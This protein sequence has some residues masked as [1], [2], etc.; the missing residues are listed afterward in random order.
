VPLAVGLAA[1]ARPLSQLLGGEGDPLDAAVTYLRIS[2]LGVPFVL[3]SLVGAGVF[4]GVADL[5]TPLAIVFTASAANLLVEII[6]VYGLDLGIAGSA[7]STVL[8][9][10]LAAVAYLALMRP[11]LRAAPSARPDRA[12]LSALLRAG[13]H[14][15]LRV[16][17]L[18]AAFAIATA[19]AARVD[20]A[21][22]AAHQVVYTMF[23]LLALSLDAFAIPAQTLVAEALGA[24]DLGL[25][26]V[27]G[28][29]VLVLSAVVGAGVSVV[30]A[31]VA[32][33]VARVFTADPT[34]TS[35]TTAGLV[36][37]AAVLLPGAVAFALDGVLIG[38]G[39]VRYLG[40]AMVISLAIYLPFA[41]L[42]LAVPSIGIV[43]VW[44]ALL[45]WMLSRAGLMTRRFRGTAWLR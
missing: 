5:R 3:V 29:R 42:P 1:L 25:A 44:V 36:V 38:A 30:L 10:V 21:T 11:H 20:T 23:T 28:E 27:V 40:R 22:V 32:P 13:G 37:L 12:E 31:L 15:V 17:S 24:H 18:I 35:R 19:V 33:L 39:D 2:A 45:V 14:L 41:A 26:R 9:Q 4:R 34:V 6:A 7:W 16:A 43:G 8:V